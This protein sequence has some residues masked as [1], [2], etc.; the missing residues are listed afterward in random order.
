MGV[1]VIPSF[2]FRFLGFETRILQEQTCRKVNMKPWSKG[3]LTDEHCKSLL[4]NHDLEELTNR[5]TR[6]SRWSEGLSWGF[7]LFPWALS[8][9]L[10]FYFIRDAHQCDDPG[11]AVYC[12]FPTLNHIWRSRLID[13]QHLQILL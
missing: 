1:L 13:N 8:I 12:T 2:S 11:L 10:L 4:K 9:V 3:S 5:R 6:T 7:R